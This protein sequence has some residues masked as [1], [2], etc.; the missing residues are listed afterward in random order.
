L[1]QILDAVDQVYQAFDLLSVGAEKI[2][3]QTLIEAHS[4]LLNI[5]SVFVYKVTDRSSVDIAN[6]FKKFENEMF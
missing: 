4:L 2:T 5:K 1:S 6:E 3:E